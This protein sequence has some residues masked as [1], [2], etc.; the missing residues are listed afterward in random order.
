MTETPMTLAALATQLAAG[1]TT[2]RQLTDACLAAAEDPAGEG[3]LAYLTIYAESARAE[4][5]RWDEMR[6][7]GWSVPAPA[8]VPISIKDLFDVAGEVTRAGSKVFD[9]NPPAA[10]DAPV[11]RRLRRAGFVILGKTNMTEFAYS[12][13]GMNAHFGTPASPYDRANRRIPGG[14]T[15]GGA[16]SVAD[17]MAAATIGTDT[18][19]SCRIPAAFCGITGFK[20]SSHRVPKDGVVPLSQSMD[21]VGPLANSVSCCAIL[22]DVLTGG[23]GADA[24]ARPAEGLRIGVVGNYVT[25]GLD[26]VVAAAFDMALQRLVEAGVHL[27]PVSLPEIDDL[28]T[29]NR[30]GGIVGAEA[31][32]F[33]RPFVETRANLYDPWVLSRF[34]AGKAQSAAD[35]IDT[36]N[37]RARIR[38]AVAERTAAF[39]AVA[40]PTV[41]IV[42]PP[43]ADLADTAVSNPT[44]LMTLRNTAVGNF[45][46]RPSISIPCHEPGRAPVGFMLMGETGGDRALFGVAKALEPAIRPGG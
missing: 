35:Y 10:A 37:H 15:S 22:D 32:A 21:S 18:G 2:S 4:A 43:M 33:H 25:E 8:G 7:K 6:A 24:T 39:D 9:G 36:V 44:N 26:D 16:V 12:G 1:E 46:D 42:P 31:Y 13:L 14:S 5:D 28:P 45:L 38:A 23:E 29:I 34:D 30:R 17:G 19:G 41:A 27:A 40:L 11:V 20:P 3:G